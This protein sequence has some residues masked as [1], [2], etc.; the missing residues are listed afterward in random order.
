MILSELSIKRPVFA[1]MLMFGLIIFGGVSFNRLGVSQLPDV[2]FPV[3]TISVIWE[4]A[5]P[6]VIEAEIVDTIE[7]AVIA[8]EGIEEL[9]STIRQGQASISLEFSIDRN[10]DAALQEVQASISRIRL[11]EDVDLPTIRKQNPEDQ[12]IMWLGVSSPDLPLKD[13]IAYV[14][15][16]IKD[17]FQILPGVGEIFLG[18]YT[19]RNL[20][21]WVE[22]EK[23]KKYELTILDVRDALQRGHIESAAGILENEKQEINVRFMGE[24][25]SPE[26]VGN[27]LISNR[28]GR[29]IY[30]AQIRIKDLGRVEDGLAEV[31]RVSRLN[32][33]PG[34]GIGIRKQRGANAVEI[35]ENVK[36][37]MGEI[38]E[39]LPPNMKINLNFD[40]TV[41]VKE[42]VEETEFTL[43]LSAIVTGFVC[44]L[45]LGSLSPTFNI[46]LSI[47][48]S[49]I[50]TFTVIYFF[51]FTLNLFTILALALAIGIVVDDAIMVLENIYR[52]KAMGKNRVIASLDGAREITFPAV[53]A[54]IAVI[55]IFLPVA[56]MEGVIGKFFFQFGVTLSAAVLLS[57][58]EA[59][60]ITPMRCS[61]MMASK[62]S[63][64]RFAK[65]LDRIF[66]SIA[67]SYRFLLKY[68]LIF[69]WPVVI[70]S[71]IIFAL[72][73]NILP[74]LRKEFIPPQDQSLFIARIETPTG[75]SLNSTSE[76]VKEIEKYFL[77]RHDVLRAFLTVGGYSGGESNSGTIFISLVPR[78][79]RR[80]SQQE[81]MQE[82]RV[83]FANRQDIK[84]FVQDL[85]TRGFSAK[86]GFPLDLNLRGPEWNVLE[87]KS[88]EII[89]R[90]EETGLVEDLNTDYK[91][92][93][94]EVRIDPRRDE[95]TR[96]GVP[97]ETISST[98]AAGIGG[99]RQGKFTGDGRR[100]DV[101]L[102][103]D[104]NEREVVS[105][106][107][108]LMV[109][110]IHGEIIP[111]KDLV[112][113][114]EEQTLQTITRRNRER[115]VS[116]YANIAD[117]KSQA[118][119]LAK[120]QSIANEILPPQYRAF[121]GGGAQTFTE[122]FNSLFFVLWLGVLVAYMVL[123]SQFNSFVH[124]LVVLLSMPFSITG[125]LLALYLAN[126][127]INLYSMIGIILLM[128][129]VKKNAIL[130]IEFTNHKRFEEGM[131]VDE[132]ILE[133]C[134]IRL[135]PV[136]MTSFATLA[137]ALPPALAIGPGAETRIPMSL[138]IVGGVF[139]ST[140]FTL[141]VI[142]C[143]YKMMSY[144]ESKGDYLNNL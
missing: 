20:R 40:A 137:A 62:E 18:G 129:I 45:F 74:L 48:T 61:Q 38:A 84:L 114:K 44:W 31:R 116:I 117:G 39:T 102:Q 109:R 80:L 7:Q 100:Y 52:H 16:K 5:A 112:T 139:V 104:S 136:L 56:F 106:L 47:P 46:L 133:A 3:L 15:A 87:D 24:G 2:D 134:P 42:A 19:E 6:E 34:I 8:V 76:V 141:F 57:L 118:D 89:K 22:N 92:G 105:D 36:K 127:S 12:P 29:P 50:G 101:R 113:L 122:S 128:G 83:A 32:G 71:A 121:L 108:N 110:N 68:C 37:R 144:F 23:L 64:G 58:L 55:A 107:R 115:S 11:P 51:G 131:S 25:I 63:E 93:Q 59:I 94:P 30:G 126:Q 140:F 65:L 60:T 43:V 69:R 75:S 97:I 138:T 143:A 78:T 73:L 14:E 35:G 91:K 120:A 26:A 77:S 130:L 125:A 111:V 49:I 90:L 79:E 82:V 54:T 96:L 67:N 10:I 1:W 27:I 53:A 124:P 21:V 41:F 95:A 72:S 99:I 66:N 13:L 86:R 142:P 85:S 81:I 135:R 4:G 33:V 9:T 98:V 17:Q 88:S 70:L 103:L 132:A 119:A 28:G 123:A